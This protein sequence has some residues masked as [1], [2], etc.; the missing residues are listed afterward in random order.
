MQTMV[1]KPFF[2]VRPFSNLKEMLGQSVDLYGNLPA[3]RFRE[4]PKG[5]VIRRTY[6][7]VGSDVNALGTALLS[8]GLADKYIAIIGEN[9][10]RWSIAHLAVVNG[11]G[12]SVPLD[13]LL[14]QEEVLALLRRGHVSAVF[15]DGSFLET[16]KTA[17]QTLPGI[18][19][20]IC[21]KQSKA[22]R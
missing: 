5:E 17:R 18:E 6:R 20:F 11:V 3:F 19:T 8:L 14:P 21:M 22:S 4:D 10:Y 13:R 12:I 1:T 9:G 7:E 15:F 16:M 2:K